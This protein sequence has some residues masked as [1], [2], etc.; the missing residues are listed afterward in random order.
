MGLS[1]LGQQH[2]PPVHETANS[3]TSC[4]MSHKSRNHK[5]TLPSESLGAALE[6]TEFKS[7]PTGFRNKILLSKLQHMPLQIFLKLKFLTTFFTSVFHVTSLITVFMAQMNPS[8]MT[9]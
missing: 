6:C 4:K 8:F 9:P 2:E 1:F 3:C 7:F 5:V